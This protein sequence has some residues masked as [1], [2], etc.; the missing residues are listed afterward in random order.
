MQE[1]H[2]FV[3]RQAFSVVVASSAGSVCV[4]LGLG[5][6]FSLVFGS[7]RSE[8]AAKIFRNRVRRCLINAEDDL[9]S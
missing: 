2:P 9:V 8:I 5:T 3:A 7:G 1:G 6:W 4:L